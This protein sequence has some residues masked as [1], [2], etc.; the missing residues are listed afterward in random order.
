MEASRK[1]ALK[2][3][4][5]SIAMS[6]ALPKQ[7]PNLYVTPELTFKFHYFGMRKMHLVI[8]SASFCSFSRRIRHFR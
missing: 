7:E 1:G 8:T 6:I 2:A 4:G 5:K 3:G